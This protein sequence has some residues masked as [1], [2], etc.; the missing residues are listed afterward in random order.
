MADPITPDQ[1][2]ELLSAPEAMAAAGIPANLRHHG[3]AD[4]PPQALPRP[5]RQPHSVLIRGSVGV[6][7]SSMAAALCRA[8]MPILGHAENR[9]VVTSCRWVHVPR[10]LF[11]WSIWFALPEFLKKSSPITVDHL[12]EQFKMIVLDD[13]GADRGN[14]LADQMLYLLLAERE[15]LKLVTVVTTNC[16]PDEL[17]A[18]S[19]RIE[20]RLAAF[21]RV[22]LAGR[23]RR[24]ATA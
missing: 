17:K 14:A 20:T 2:P 5:M 6:G 21:E 8:W 12:N 23:D 16:E 4:F 11:D 3:P 19:P 1:L 13:V 15:A 18:W 10:W 9:T 22:V 7:K 24:R